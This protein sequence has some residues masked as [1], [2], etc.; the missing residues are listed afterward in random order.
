MIVDVHTHF[1]RFDRDCTDQVREDLRRCQMDPQPWCFTAEDYLQSIAAADA[2]V[3]FGLRAAR[4]GW[5]VPNEVVAAHAARYP[6]R[7]IFFAAIDPAQP[8]YLEELAYCHRE[9]KCQGVKVG[10]VYQGV[11]PLDPRNYALYAYCQTHGLPI[12]THMATTFSSGVPLDYARP[13]HMDQVACDFPDLKIV[14]A[15]L[16]HPWMEETIAVIRH[17]PNVYADCSA[18]FHRPWQLYH[19]LR[20]LVEYR[21]QGKV[22]FGSDFPAATTEQSLQGLRAMCQHSQQAGLPPVPEEMIEEIIHRDSLS[23]LG[24]KLSARDC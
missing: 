19:A 16:G 22:L 8:D 17:S 6:D 9:L 24:L 23:L 15:H 5:Q 10:P 20:L 12:L 4:T 3:V 13:V 18:L 1:L 2:A 7:L 11:H 14:L 21:A